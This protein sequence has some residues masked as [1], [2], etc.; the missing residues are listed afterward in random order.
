MTCRIDIDFRPGEGAVLRLIG[1]VERRGF[2]VRA[3][4]LPETRAGASARL[5]LHVAPRDPA[6]RVETVCAQLAK[7]YDVVAV[8]SAQLQA[9]E[10]AS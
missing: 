7:M 9:L 1:L 4:T 3:L 5:T 6:R 2:V 10:A 8:T